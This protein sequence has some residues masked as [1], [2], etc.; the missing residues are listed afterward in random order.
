MLRDR[1]P[2]SRPAQAAFLG[3]GP[4]RLAACAFGRFRQ[5]TFCRA[6]FG[7]P[8]ARPSWGCALPSRVAVG[9]DEDAGVTAP[10]RGSA[11]A[12]DRGARVPG[13]GEQRVDPFR[14][15]D[16]VRQRESDVVGLVVHASARVTAERVV[17]RLRPQRSLKHLI[18]ANNLI[19]LEPVRIPWVAGF[20]R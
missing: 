15:A 16:V 1:P 19:Q 14:R 13:L 9:V 2:S 12:G 3:R 8:R 17:E 6:S 10:E 4:V 20:T 18:S 7:R 5:T 11:G